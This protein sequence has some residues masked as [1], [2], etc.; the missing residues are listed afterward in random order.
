[1]NST[2]ELKIELENSSTTFCS[3]VLN[4]LIL[5]FYTHH[6]VAIKVLDL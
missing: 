6:D 4:F 5:R 3:G 1:M 2:T